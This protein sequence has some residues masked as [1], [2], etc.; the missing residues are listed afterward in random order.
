MFLFGELGAV[1]LLANRVR[2][3]VEWSSWF[4]DH[5]YLGWFRIKRLDIKIRVEINLKLAH[6]YTC[7]PLTLPRK[8]VSVCLRNG[9]LAS[10]QNVYHPYCLYKR[11]TPIP[12]L[13]RNYELKQNDWFSIKTKWLVINQ[14]KM[15]GP[16]ILPTFS[17]CSRW[18]KLAT[19]SFQWETW[20][21]FFSFSYLESS[22]GSP[23]YWTSQFG[24]RLKWLFFE[25]RSITWRWPAVPLSTNLYAFDIG[26][27][28]NLQG[29]GSYFDSTSTLKVRLILVIFCGKLSLATLGLIILI[30][31]IGL[32]YFAANVALF[33]SIPLAACLKE[34]LRVSSITKYPTWNSIWINR[35]FRS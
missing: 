22:S 10:L 25:R 5:Y 30:I 14:S 8:T 20:G 31:S 34:N 13:H 32:T 12:V 28:R 6:V 23:C 16:D 3:L 33:V 2:P 29:V 9:A 1:S 7:A 26:R 21:M 4:R 11:Y 17:S 15:S 18:V 19:I 35:R 27:L 24:W